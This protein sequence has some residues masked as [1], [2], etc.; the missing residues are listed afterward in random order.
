MNLRDVHWSLYFLGWTAAI[1]AAGALLGAV[2]IPLAGLV[3]ATGKTA[4]QLAVAGARDLGFYFFLW[5][6]GIA[7]VLCV[8]RAYRRRHPEG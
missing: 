6:P 1:T 5:A 4:A 8:M 2:V 7:L 3:F